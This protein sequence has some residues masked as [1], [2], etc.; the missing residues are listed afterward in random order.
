MSRIAGTYFTD[1]SGK[2]INV[3]EM[4]RSL[5][6]PQNWDVK[7]Q[8]FKNAAMGWAGSRHQN[9]EKKDNCLVVMDGVLFNRDEFTRQGSDAAIVLELY[10]QY[11]FEGALK[12]I[13][14]DFSIA[15]Y[16]SHL[17]L[18]WLARDRFGCKPLYYHF[19]DNRFLFSSRLKSLI[20]IPGIFQGF[21]KKF[22]AIFA[23]SHYRSFDNDSEASPYEGISQLPA[24]HYIQVQGST[25][26][27]SAYWR[28]TDSA[29]IAKDENSLAEQYRSL[30][31][32]S[33]SDRLKVV[34]KPAFTLSGGMDS[35]SVLGSA[36]SIK[37][38]RQQAFSTVYEDKTYDESLEIGS[39]L[40]SAVEKWNP[41]QIGQPDI[42]D[43]VEKMI[44][45]HDEPVATATWLPHYHLSQKVAQEGF[46]SIFGGLGGDELN[47]GEYEYFFFHFADLRKEGKEKELDE[48][49]KFWVQY[50]DHPIYK[51]NKDVMEEAL[52]RLVDF[53]RPGVC[54]SD[55]KRL[56][57]YVPALRKDFFD[58]TN[59]EPIM[60]H[61]FNKY[62][63]NRT[64]Q[65]I[66]RET[67]PC[68]LRAEDR[69]TMAFGLDNFL[70]FLD[71]RV[72]EFMFRIPGDL[73]IKKGVTKHL[74]R[75]AMKDILPEETRTRIKKTGWNAPAHVW[76][77]GKGQTLLK[78]IV[79][80]Q[81]FRE[82][83]IYDVE[84]VKNLIE[85]HNQIIQKGK[86]QDNHM[87]FFWQLVNL[88]LWLNSIERIK[89]PLEVYN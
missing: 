70:P 10:Q 80:S 58:L 28:L 6:I 50:H 75:L 60:D 33:V 16:D 86:E 59:F 12:K 5:N 49:M 74:L 63:K 14:G 83:G 21:N 7:I 66:Y 11:G 85:E 67:M 19:K 29:E 84:Y 4:L 77:S 47:A 1:Q 22:V 34:S 15:L 20:S 57:R 32:Q 64:Y 18:L 88:E 45:L 25:I 51:K 3:G 89:K 13:N 79:H 73:K 41:I 48:E 9:I 17:N 46:D 78:D 40:D 27:K 68:C 87:M 26:R 71:Y 38:E 54:L 37:R 81:S 23:A 36:V 30:L 8:V 39:M 69:Q 65:D 56:N 72:V 53:S 82:R 76:F 42:L 24:A 31:L 35:S 62:L 61:S 2:S 52:S 43:D 55:K 44:D